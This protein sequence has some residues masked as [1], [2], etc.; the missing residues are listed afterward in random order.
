MVSL[1]RNTVKSHCPGKQP[2]EVRG[3]SV[4]VGLAGFPCATSEEKKKAFDR[5]GISRRP[6]V[7]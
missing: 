3:G 6:L 2:V 7:K 4:G 1:P 5:E